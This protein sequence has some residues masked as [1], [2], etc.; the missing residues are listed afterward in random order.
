M[1]TGIFP[2]DI[3]G[4][5]TYVP[6]IATALVARGHACTVLTLSDRLDH[7]DRR[8]AF[9]VLRLPRQGGKLQRWG[10]TM[11][12]IAQLGRQADVLFVHGLALEAVLANRVLNKPLV[13][14]VV[15]DL[16]WERAT[17]LGWVQ[18]TFEDFQ[19]RAHGLP[20]GSLK[21]LRAWWTRQGDTVIVPSRY[22][23]RYVGLWGVPPHKLQVIYNALESH[24]VRHPASVPLTTPIKMV[25]VGRLVP[26]KRLG[27]LLHAVAPL[28]QVGLLIIGDGPER[29][30]LQ[31]LVQALH[32]T[33]RVHFAGQCSVATTH[34]LMAACDL[35]VLNSSYEGLPHVVL[36]AMAL[37]LPVVATAVGGTPEVVEDGQNGRL[38]PLTDAHAL[39]AV[40][41]HLVASPR[42]RSR[43][44]TAARRTATRFSF[45][46]MV[47]ATERVLLH[48]AFPQA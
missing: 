44:A 46:T 9:R 22:L 30:S 4:P 8:Y 28:T 24:P 14:K 18:E 11:R 33:E 41:S 23:A 34:A 19:T 37:G 35:F 39:G 27:E 43:M 26:W 36:E 2:P 17:N 45:T 20:L 40:L 12:I 1:I 38:I 6:R 3:G 48:Q 13:H 42:E 10:Q 15:G 25:T 5:A 32:L 31:H 47:D 21:A 16:A 7:D 29:T